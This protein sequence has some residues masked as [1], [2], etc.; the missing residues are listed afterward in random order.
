MADKVNLLAFKGLLIE[1]E[2]TKAKALKNFGIKG[3]KDDLDILMS[4]NTEGNKIPLDKLIRN[5]NKLS[6][7]IKL[8]LSLQYHFR[9]IHERYAVYVDSTES[10][11]MNES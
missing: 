6:P 9:D 5:M 3:V 1:G 4:Y 2:I 7:K 8:M 10:M 11:E